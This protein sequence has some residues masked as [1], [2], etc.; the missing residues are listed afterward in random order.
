ME[1]SKELAKYQIENEDW[2]NINLVD[3]KMKAENVVSLFVT[4]RNVLAP[5][6]TPEE[7]EL[8]EKTKQTLLNYLDG[9]IQNEIKPKE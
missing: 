4:L 6:A 1:K 2:K 8:I 9:F 5:I 7:S 3:L